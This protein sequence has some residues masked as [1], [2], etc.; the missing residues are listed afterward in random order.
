M[1]F[2]G[3]KKYSDLG[4]LLMRLGVGLTFMLIH[5]WPKI[6]GGVERWTGLGGRFEFVTG[7]G[8][9]PE[10][11]GFMA[12]LSEFAGGFL[13]AIGLLTRPACLFLI[14]TML[15]ATLANIMDGSSYNHALKMVAVFVGLFFV[16]PGKYSLDKS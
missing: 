8:V 9:F 11:W 6:I 14:F 13:I 15:I 4:L 10:F 2:R 3:M 1:L 16:G 5:G 12:A 7:I